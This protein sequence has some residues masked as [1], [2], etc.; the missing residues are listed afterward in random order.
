MIVE[1]K[2]QICRRKLAKIAESSAYNIDPCTKDFF[3][4]EIVVPDLSIALQLDVEA[5]WKASFGSGHRGPAWRGSGTIKPLSSLFPPCSLS[6]FSTQQLPLAGI[7]RAKTWLDF[8][9][10]IYLWNRVAIFF[11][12]HVTNTG[13]MYQMNTK[14]IKYL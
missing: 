12:V 2:C 4:G 10:K 3:L 1:E 6:V 11:L 9:R 14:C 7:L 5:T 13:K 8:R